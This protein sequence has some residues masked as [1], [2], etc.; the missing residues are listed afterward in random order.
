MDPEVAREHLEPEVALRLDEFVQA[1][2]P[3]FAESQAPLALR[4]GVLRLE[5]ARLLDRKLAFGAQIAEIEERTTASTIAGAAADALDGRL[6]G[7]DGLA[8][9]VT[10]YLEDAEAGAALHEVERALRTRER[11]VY[12]R[13]EVLEAA[14]P[15]EVEEDE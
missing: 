1:P 12:R 13:P 7:D 11:M 4:D 14:V 3:P 2:L 9:D 10:R 8:E 6:P 5:R 15:Q